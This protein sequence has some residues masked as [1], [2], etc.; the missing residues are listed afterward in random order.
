LQQRQSEEQAALQERQRIMRDIHDG[1]GAHL[2]GLL[3]MM[4][5]G[6]A[7][8]E[9]LQEQ[10]HAA[11]DE[12]RMA[13]DSLQ[14][15]NGDLTTV[16]ATLRY[17]LQPRLEAAGLQV[18]WAVEALPEMRSLTPTTVLNV[19]RILLEAFTNVLK[20]AGA[21]MVRV[22]ARYVDTPDRLELEVQDDGTGIPEARSRISGHG[23]GN[24][25]ARAQSISASISIEP[26]KPHGTCV[27][28]ALLLS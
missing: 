11:L 13:V 26:A 4:K 15:V 10:A 22:T 23:L 20:H 14:P 19:Q 16:L 3:S 5:K 27:K 21:S 8:S 2:V 24:M 12:L 28:L 1:V 9:A 25:R 18:E 17:R 7:P 6:V